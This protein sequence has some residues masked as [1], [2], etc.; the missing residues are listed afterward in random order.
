MEVVQVINPAALDSALM[1]EFLEQVFPPD[2]VALLGGF[3]ARKDLLKELVQDPAWRL[4][5]GVEEG[6]LAGCCL[7]FS[8]PPGEPLLRPQV[9]HFHNDG[10]AA[11]RRALMDAWIAWFK[12]NGHISAWAINASDRPDSLWARA[13]R[14]AGEWRKVGSIMECDLK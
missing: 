13:F 9:M 7:A 1:A 2:S 5:V 11:L 3:P 12:S 14:V 8:P 6:R 10:T 4:W